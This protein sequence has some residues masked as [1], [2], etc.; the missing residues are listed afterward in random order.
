MA[1]QDADIHAAV[2]TEFAALA[3]DVHARVDS[4]GC[5]T[6]SQPV[7]LRIGAPLA[8]GFER[9]MTSEVFLVADPPPRHGKTELVKHAVVHRLCCDPT[10][11]I[12]YAA[13]D[14]RYD[15]SIAARVRSATS[16]AT[17]SNEY[18]PGL[19]TWVRTS[20]TAGT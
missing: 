10:T 20:S 5:V 1:D 4:D 16:S 18:A 3:G 7:A 19:P 15:S 17:G 13:Y 2:L 8:E 14:A 12:G 9:A 6:S 11:R